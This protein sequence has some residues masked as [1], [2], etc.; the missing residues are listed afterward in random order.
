M[1][2]RPRSYSLSRDGSWQEVG[3]D[4]ESPGPSSKPS[5]HAVHSNYPPYYFSRPSYDTTRSFEVRG[6][7][8]GIPTAAR[9]AVEANLYRGGSPPALD[10]QPQTR[11]VMRTAG[12]SST[13]NVVPSIHAQ[14]SQDSFNSQR[15]HG[16]PVSERR[17][18]SASRGLSPYSRPS[19]HAP[20]SNSAR[21]STSRSSSRSGSRPRAVESEVITQPQ[22]STP[23]LRPPKPIV[24]PEHQAVHHTYYASVPGSTTYTAYTT[25]EVS[26]VSYNGLPAHAAAPV[27][28]ISTVQARPELYPRSS[29]RTSW[30]QSLRHSWTLGSFDWEK[31]SITTNGTFPP[32]SEFRLSGIDWEH[33]NYDQQRGV[34]TLSWINSEHSGDQDIERLPWGQEPEHSQHLS[35]SSSGQDSAFDKEKNHRA[36]DERNVRMSGI[37][38]DPTIIFWDGESDKENPMNW[39]MR[40]KRVAILSLALFTFI[41]PLASSMFAPSVPQLLSEFGISSRLLSQFVVSVYVFGFAIGPL[42]V[43]PMSEVYG[44]Y[45]VYIVGYIGFIGFTIGCGLATSMPILIV[46]RFFAGCFGVTPVAIGGGTIADLFPKEERGKFMGLWALGPMLGPMV[47]PVGGGYLAVALG[48]R[49]V[50]WVITMASG[51]LFLITAA[52]TGETFAPVL[53]ARKTARLRR[54][55]ANTNLRSK[56]DTGLPPSTVFWR[57]VQRP[58]HMF[59]RSPIV[60]AMSIYVSFVYGILYV[61]FT[62]FTFVFVEN[63]GWTPQKSG[64]VYIGLGIGTIIGL[65]I[66]G[67]TSDKLCQHLAKKHNNG[68]LRPEYRL[69]PLMYGGVT[70]PLGLFLYGWATQYTLYW[71]IPL[72]GTVLVGLGIIQ[73]FMCI[74]TYLVDTFGMHAASA[75]AVNTVLRSIAAAFLP[76]A[77]LDMYDALGLGWGNS[78]LGFAACLL[79][80]LPGIFYLYGE[81]VRTNPKYKISL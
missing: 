41:T 22:V 30:R 71:P 45:P 74:Q 24:I 19:L 60:A 34:S 35:A 5:P 61:L 55:T 14:P 8:A 9:N 73:T 44:R 33:D 53:L 67:S 27:E 21:P 78:V 66:L 50:F 52:F 10:I 20:R 77:G 79:V 12:S 28:D 23:S 46:F 47:G 56:M 3:L 29:S 59:L 63:Y 38:P 7:R 62:T 11:P 16:V 70:V 4:Q 32:F 25:P 48:W 54:K 75:M 49:W 58:T 69:P 13:S 37:L 2:E 40:K 57:A 18:P 36:D 81:R 65:F 39:T 15:A 42:I 43:S 68:I 64:L 80:P 76:M 26:D 72:A 31:S 1:T 51:L 6:E 17:A